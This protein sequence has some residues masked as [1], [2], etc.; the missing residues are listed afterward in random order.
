MD[1]PVEARECIAW[2]KLLNLTK[3]YAGSKL[4]VRLLE[5]TVNFTC[6]RDP[7]LPPSISDKL[8]FSSKR[9]SWS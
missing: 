1:N 2:I 8:Q 5:V 6:N 4:C 9:K 3:K 7:I